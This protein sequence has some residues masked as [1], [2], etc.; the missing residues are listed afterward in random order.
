LRAIG[1]VPGGGGID[2]ADGLRA[3][4]RCEDAAFGPRLGNAAVPGVLRA[5]MI[6]GPA[7]V[8]RPV[9]KIVG[10]AGSFRPRY[11]AFPAGFRAL[12]IVLKNP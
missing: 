4:K 2:G 1:I 9:Q 5:A 7:D 8:N 6:S 11:R 12:P 10:V 3:I